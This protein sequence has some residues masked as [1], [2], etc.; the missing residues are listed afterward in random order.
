MEPSHIITLID[1]GPVLVELLPSLLVVDLLGED[2]VPLHLHDFCSRSLQLLD[3]GLG[4]DHEDDAAVGAE[5]L[6]SLPP[7]LHPVG[8]PQIWHDA[9]WERRNGELG[10]HWDGGHEVLAVAAGQVLD[11]AGLERGEGCAHGV[12]HHAH[13]PHLDDALGLHAS[14]GCW[15]HCWLGIFNVFKITHVFFSFPKI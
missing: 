10:L 9:G 13:G 15:S 5:V 4:A 2:S 8:Q 12:G 11:G 3:D 6:E 1:E 7:A 14:P